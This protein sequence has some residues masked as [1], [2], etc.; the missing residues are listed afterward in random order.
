[1]PEFPRKR[2][3]VQRL[4][5][6]LLVLLAVD[7]LAWAIACQRLGAETRAVIAQ[8]EQDGWSVNVGNDHWG[9][10]PIAAEVGL[11]PV[12]VRAAAFPPGLV[13]TAEALRVRLG[14]SHPTIATVLVAGKQTLTANGLPTV[15]VRTQRAAF[16]VDLTGREL[17]HATIA[18]LDAALPAGSLTIAT[19]GLR[20]PPGALAADM[21]GI[22][23]AAEPAG[24]ALD[25]SVPAKA[26]S[27]DRLR[28]EATAAP[29]FPAAATPA[30]N[31]EAWRAAAGRVTIADAALQWGPLAA[32]GQ[33]SVTID[34]A[35]QPAGDG[36]IKAVGLP[37]LL[38]RLAASAVITRP[39]A[40]AAKAV[41]AILAAP[42]P[43]GGVT[44]PLSLRDGVLS[45]ARI[46]VLRFP[47]LVW[48]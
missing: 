39:E 32:T 41:L 9:G 5:I 26:P 36:Q 40:V 34:A 25:G 2:R 42:Q 46:A 23:L 19:M 20:F 43:G 6:A 3:V 38:D 45:V 28:F 16:S 1:M 35:L 10:W 29:P 37:A 47:P 12:A 18:G 31:A 27:I 48:Q 4:L 7:T 15:P 21:A 14:W 33:F 30:E 17:V 44:L 8:A 22:A 13:W 24:I 11:T